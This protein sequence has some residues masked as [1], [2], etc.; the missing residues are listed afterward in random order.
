MVVWLIG[1]SGSGKTTLA[2]KIF[3]EI[4]PKVKNIVKIDGDVIREI[5]C[6]D[7]GYTKSDRKKNAKRISSLCKFLENNKINVICSI[8]S[9]FES[10]RMWNRKNFKNYY[11]VFIDVDKDILMKRDSK[12]LYKNYMKGKIK[13]V[14]GYDINFEKPENS[15]LTIKNNKSLDYFLNFSKKIKEKIINS[16]V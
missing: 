6:N 10:D 1:L 14:V 2:D 15:D 12:G 4:S 13:N 7:L 9:V 11:E 8:L 3:E 16:N 5:F